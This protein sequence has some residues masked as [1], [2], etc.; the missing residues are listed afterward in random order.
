MS[1]MHT[2]N[3]GQQTANFGQTV[4]LVCTNC[5]PFEKN[6]KGVQFG[7]QKLSFFGF[8]LAFFPDRKIKKT[9]QIHRI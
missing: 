8:F 7:V 4:P 3:F 5:T 2:A 6:E 9:L 1:F